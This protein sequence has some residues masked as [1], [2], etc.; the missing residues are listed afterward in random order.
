MPNPPHPDENTG[1]DARSLQQ[2][3]DDFV[4]YNKHLARRARMTSQISKPYFRDWTNMQYH[5]GKSFI[6]NERLFRAE[7]ALWFPNFFGRTLRTDVKRGRRDGYG[8]YGRDTTSVLKG[9]V[10]V[11]CVYSSE[12]ARS[13]IATFCAPKSNPELHDIVNK[14]EDIA[15]MVDINI[16]TARLRWWILRL[17]SYRLRSAL[18]PEGQA[19]YFMVGREVS[20][21]VKEAIGLLNDKVG[22]VY[23]VDEDCKIRW[24]GSARAEEH[25]K[26]SMVKGLKRL[27]QDARQGGGSLDDKALLATVQ[28]VVELPR[29]S[30]AG[31]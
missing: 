10:S 14:N 11:V 26:V 18:S 17:F 20:D 16:E 9:R 23:L 31:S 15:Q 27:V 28:E 8:G 13:Q 4:D 7:H 30:A 25:E 24:A 21:I 5:K 22:Y 1:I 2:R 3:R 12:W 19:R 6:S 29:S